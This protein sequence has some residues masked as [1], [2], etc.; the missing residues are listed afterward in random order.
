MEGIVRRGGWGKETK[1]E[2]MAR[3]GPGKMGGGKESR[4]EEGKKGRRKVGG[5]CRKTR[6]RGDKGK[7]EGSRESGE[8]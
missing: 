1:G 3:R 8:S 6:E 7:Q 4:R 5:G 2:K